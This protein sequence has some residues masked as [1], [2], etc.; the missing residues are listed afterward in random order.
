MQ[1][2]NF[3]KKTEKRQRS[4]KKRQKGKMF[5]ICC[6]T[7]ST[8]N[9]QAMLRNEHDLKQLDQVTYEKVEISLE[10]EKT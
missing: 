9:T 2:Q 3:A 5:R 8:F 7:K 6:E 1:K 4:L 10:L